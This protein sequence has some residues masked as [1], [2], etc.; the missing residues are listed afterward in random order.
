MTATPA[1]LRHLVLFAF[2]PG[3]PLAGLLAQFAGLSAQIAEIRAYEQGTDISTEN[4]AQGFTHA[5]LLTFDDAAACDRYLRHP[6]H[7]AFV[8]EVQPWLDKVLVFDYL[9]S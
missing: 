2:K 7:V 5:F 3:A 9:V 1:R 4:L 6:A 8:G